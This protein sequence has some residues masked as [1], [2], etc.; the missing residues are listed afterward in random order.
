MI[1]TL[2]QPKLGLTKRTDAGLLDYTNHIINSLELNAAAF[3]GILIAELK[4]KASKYADALA[5]TKDG[6]PADTANKNN[7]RTILE[8]AL[9]SMA[10]DCAE[11]ANGDDSTFLLSG[12]QIK[13]K[14]S[15]S[16]MLAAPKNFD[17]LALLIPGLLEVRFKSVKNA[18]AY[19]VYF[20]KYNT[21]PETWELLKVT[22]AGKFTI[23]DLESNQMFSAR[24]RA[25]G[26]KG[27]KGEWT[28]IVSRKTY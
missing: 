10:S 14:P 24:V 19:E 20:G 21:D 4:D 28:E 15:P 25:V 9:R 7:M 11:I 12:F 23:S 8:N 17:I 18:N 22:T 13:S 26:A 1:A 16:G 3:P 6:S 27:K 2:I 5:L